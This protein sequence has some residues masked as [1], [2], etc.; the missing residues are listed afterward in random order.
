VLVRDQVAHGLDDRATAAGT[1]AVSDLGSLTIVYESTTGDRRSTEAIAFA[2]ATGVAIAAYTS[3][4]R[5]GTQL[6]EPFEY[7]T[8]LWVTGALL[9]LVWVSLVAGGVL[10]SS[11]GDR[12]RHA[13]VG[14]L[15]TLG[16]TC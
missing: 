9:L 2:L 7:A 15:L 14:G 13:A 4:D 10:L 8:I 1:V 5:I 12:V 11:G 16:P 6:V 3:I